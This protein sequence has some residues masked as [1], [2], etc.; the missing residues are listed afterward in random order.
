M[1]GASPRRTE[2]RRLLLGAGRF[3]DDLQ[4]DGMLHL[5][6]VRSVL[7]HARIIGIGASQALARPG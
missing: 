7:P 1:I 5:G 3:L 4:R 2:D 6:V